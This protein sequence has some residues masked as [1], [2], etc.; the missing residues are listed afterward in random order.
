[1]IGV[2]MKKILLITFLLAHIVSRA[3]ADYF[4]N[5][6]LEKTDSGLEKTRIEL[7]YNFGEFIS[8]DEN[9]AEIGLFTPYTI[10]DWTTLL[11]VRG[12][13]FSGGKWGAS[14]GFGVRKCKSMMDEAALGV[15]VFYDYLRGHTRHNFHRIGVGL[16]W[17][18]CNWDFRV[19]GYFPVNKKTNS[20]NLCS[21][22]LGDGFFATSQRLEFAYTGFDAEVGIPIYSLYGFNLYGAAGP[23]YFYR[24]HFEHFF[25]GYGR[26]RLDWKTMISLELR[27]SY[28]HVYK[29]NAQGEILLS[30]PF[31]FLC[32]GFCKTDCG[33]EGFLNQPI[34]RNGVILKDSCC[35]WTWN[36]D[37]EN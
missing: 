12:Y 29:T 3:H 24:S 8:I 32:S 14:A 30:I 18:N 27:V 17:L 6:W 13:R 16:E 22:D 2:F 4:P 21:F 25:G 28:D 36:W 19:N 23:Y 1:M 7:G 26:L 35:D 20:G 11:D 10:N 15:N 5:I 9:Y 31:D 33:C 37:D 34:R